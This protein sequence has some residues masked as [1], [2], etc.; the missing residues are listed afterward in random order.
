MLDGKKTIIGAVF[1]AVC[2]L[3]TGVETLLSPQTVVLFQALTGGLGVFFGGIGIAG[4]AD[5]FTR[6]MRGR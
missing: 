4:K 5:K 1:G 6:A 3:L 2:F